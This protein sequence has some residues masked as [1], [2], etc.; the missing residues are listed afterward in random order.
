M[1]DSTQCSPT[2]SSGV[3]ENGTKQTEADPWRPD[4][5][6]FLQAILTAVSMSMKGVRDQLQS[7]MSD[8]M[9]QMFQEAEQAGD[10]MEWQDDKDPEPPPN[11]AA[12]CSLAFAGSV[13]NMSESDDE[14]Q[15]TQGPGA[16]P[17]TPHPTQQVNP[18]P[19]NLQNPDVMQAI[20]AQY[21]SQHSQK[22]LDHTTGSITPELAKVLEKW[23]YGSYTSDEIKTRVET[24]F[25]PQNAAALIPCRIN[26]EVY[27]RLTA[28]VKAADKELRYI[29]NAVAKAAQPLAVLW[30][31]VIKAIEIRKTHDPKAPAV[32]MCGD[33][34]IFDLDQAKGQL[35][36]SLQLLVMANSHLVHK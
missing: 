29:N 24:I 36:Q 13:H 35:D 34:K 27:N 12:Q 19:D 31:A 20:L 8:M 23:F 6:D 17:T 10:Y 4:K 9:S 33:V 32:L 11:K 14:T 5:A 3:G 26:D 22:L 15:P 30:D 21:E 2:R 7:E 18:I 16:T 25:R 1:T 28:D